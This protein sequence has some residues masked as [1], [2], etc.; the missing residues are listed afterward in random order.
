MVSFQS[1]ITMNSYLFV[2]KESQNN[3]SETPIGIDF[4][5]HA[6]IT[7]ARTHQV[8]SKRNFVYWLRADDTFIGLSKEGKI[9]KK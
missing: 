8:R 9:K 5:N 1:F 3:V 7:A 6:V 4:S 2:I